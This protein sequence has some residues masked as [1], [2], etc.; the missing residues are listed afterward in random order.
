MAIP[1]RVASIHDLAEGEMREVQVGDLGVLLCRVGGA[2]HAVGAHCTHYGAPL[3]TG[4]LRGTCVV[5]PWHHAMFDVTT[6]TRLAPPA[7]DH[8]PRYAVEVRGG[9]VFVTVPDDAEDTPEGAP[10]RVS[11]GDPPAMA[12][13]G[14]DSRAFVVVG[15][16]AAGQAAAE[17]LRAAGF[18]GRV[19][20]VTAE[21][22]VPYDRPQLS[23][24]YA[25]GQAGDDALPLRD[26][27]FYAG[28]GIELV[29]GRRVRL[30]DAA[31]KRV[32]FED[33][34]VLPYAAALVAP[35][36]RPRR[37]DVPGADLD[38]V[39]YLRTH[40]DARRIVQA[41][42]HGQRAVL[43]GSSFIAMELAASLRGRGLDVTVASR[44]REPFEKALGPEVGRFFRG[45]HEAEGVRFH[46]ATTVERIERK[47]DGLAVVLGNGERAEGDFVVAGVGVAPATGFVEGVEKAEDGGIV[48]DA[49]LRAAD[50][51]W[52]AGDVAHYPDARSGRRVRIEHWRLAQQHG[53]RAGRNMAGE[54]VPFRGAPFFWSGQF[55]VG[56][57][58]VGH[59]ADAGAP[60]LDG[61]LEDR[62]FIAYYLDGDRVAAAAGV[63]RD[64]EMAAFHALVLAGAEP[65]A[66]EVRAGGVDLLARLRAG[67]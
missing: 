55:G 32:T 9:D 58:Y 3:A 60:V 19:L 33:G 16:G 40:E 34:E 49:E 15:G 1:R 5:C 36:G 29:E 8:L 63:G 46:L 2:F 67:Q 20:L 13:P 4:A 21:P 43:V 50:G 37:L 31:A 17:E 53:R 38:G 39:L 35:G 51:L 23:K 56:L 12:A 44:D 54:A 25:A 6:G 66:G 41:A 48:V 42:K 10:Y 52:A 30:L 61:S 62:A 7:P 18:R 28:H 27:A 57:R 14:A 64:R 47:G 24:G 22:E 11:A 26:R 65:S 59:A 45:V